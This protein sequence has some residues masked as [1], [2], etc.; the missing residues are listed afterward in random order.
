MNASDARAILG[1]KSVSAR[2]QYATT[3][4]KVHGSSSSAAGSSYTKTKPPPGFDRMTANKT[5]YSLASDDKK[6]KKLHHSILLIDSRICIDF[7]SASSSH[8]AHP[9]AQS[10]AAAPVYKPRVD[11]ATSYNIVTNKSCNTRQTWVP[12]GRLVRALRKSST[13]FPDSRSAEDERFRPSQQDVPS[14]ARHCL[15]PADCEGK[16][17]IQ[18]ILGVSYTRTVSADVC[19]DTQQPSSSGP[20]KETGGRPPLGS[21]AA[22]RPPTASGSKYY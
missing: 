5:N 7:Q 2:K 4:A 21:C 3:S 15:R 11:G 10:S 18:H 12:E 17:Y 20:A 9:A 22:L 6:C 13:S 14:R 19:V 1:A 16:P 8:F